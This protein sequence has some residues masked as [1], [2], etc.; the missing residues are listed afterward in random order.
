M[1]PESDFV[2]QD[3]DSE[4]FYD[5][6]STLVRLDVPVLALFAENDTQVDPQQGA[7]AFSEAV[8]S[9][10][11]GLSQVIMVPGAD[12]NMRVS[13]T[14]CLKEQRVRYAEEGGAEYAP[15]FLENLEDWL[16]ALS[17]RLEQQRTDTRPPN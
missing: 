5:P 2:P 14:G 1:I 4:I 16:L 7:E 6:R 3:A 12:H 11:S 15:E 9:S 13:E 10:E 8:H 17:A